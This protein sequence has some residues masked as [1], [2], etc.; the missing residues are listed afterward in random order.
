VQTMGENELVALLCVANK[1]QASACIDAYVRSSAEQLKA[2][3]L[4][5][6]E[7]LL[8][9]H[10]QNPGDFAPVLT[11]LRGRLCEL[12]L[13]NDHI[14]EN[15]VAGRLLCRHFANVPVVLNNA[16]M[17]E[18]FKCLPTKAIEWWLTHAP[19]CVDDE[20]SL[21]TLLCLVKDGGDR[22][23]HRQQQF[24]RAHIRLCNVAWLQCLNADELTDHDALSWLDLS[25]NTLMDVL[26]IRRVKAGYATAMLEPFC[27]AWAAPPRPMS[28]WQPEIAIHFS[29]AALQQNLQQNLQHNLAVRGRKSKPELCEGETVR[30]AGLD[31]TLVWQ[32]DIEPEALCICLRVHWKPLRDVV[33]FGRHVPLTGTFC[34]SSGLRIDLVNFVAKCV[35]HQAAVIQVMKVEQLPDGPLKAWMEDV[36][37]V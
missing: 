9:L 8:T 20:G 24:L 33:N 7:T 37:F 19:L 10:E 23:A 17:L 32:R 27:A 22:N 35:E 18:L 34:M 1:Y 6:I 4:S 21:L 2:V 36:A 5:H 31:M 29:K 30:V 28:T 26:L 14:V 16:D 25:A 11:Y 3:T 12:L 15:S 13:E